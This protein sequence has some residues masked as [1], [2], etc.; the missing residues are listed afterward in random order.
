[1]GRRFVL[2]HV[3]LSDQCEAEGVEGSASPTPRKRNGFFDTPYGVLR[4]T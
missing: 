3:I 1:M 4:M 2:L